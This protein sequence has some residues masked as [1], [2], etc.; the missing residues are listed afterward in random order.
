[1]W[2]STML[3]KS[4]PCSPRPGENTHV[5]T[6]LQTCKQAIE[7][8]ENTDSFVGFPISEP[9][10]SV[11]HVSKHPKNIASPFRHPNYAPT[12]FLTCVIY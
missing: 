5:Q 11:Q 10:T 2:V 1:M 8:T 9:N 4:S 6:H 3:G 7:N 12:A